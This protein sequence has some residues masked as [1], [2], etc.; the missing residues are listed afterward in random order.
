LSA[1]PLVAIG[2]MS[3]SAYLWHQPLLAFARHG[4]LTEPSKAAYATLAFLSFPLA[5]LSWRFIEQPFRA[6]GVFTRKAI[7]ISSLTGSIMFIAIGIVGHMA[8]GFD[9]RM[10]QS[11]LTAD[12]IDKK[13]NV[14]FGLNKICEETFTVSL[15]CRT[16]DAPE[17]LVWGDSYAMHLV[18]G[19][20][21]SEPDAK[22]IQ[23]T[24]SVCGPFFDAAP[25]Y[26]P[27]YPMSWA[28]GCL[29][30]TANI[31]EWLKKNRTVKYAVLSSPF[32]L[33]LS[34]GGKLL[35]RDGELSQAN[36]ELAVKEFEKTLNEIKQMGIAPIV[37]SPP[38]ANGIDLGQCLAKAAWRGLNLGDCDFEVDKI[39]QDRLDAYH[40]LERIEKTA[41]V[42]R[43]DALICNDSRCITH[44]D[45]T[46]IY[47]DV[48]HLSHEGS[49]ALGKK[50]HF[51]RRITE[52]SL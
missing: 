18:E 16:D 11:G 48:G 33:Y 14:N 39:T 45:A 23:M 46:F 26:E 8:N 1:Q 34:A 21:A 36:V 42:V 15:D 24:K 47:R 32:T 29:E 28:R 31:R 4:A 10:T 41:A 37:F 43:L 52:R 25:V 35:L 20:L 38:P 19:I 6:K 3:Y 44:L 17:I 30:F 7:F 49:A 40:F 9:G 13:L 12:L 50:Y 51:Y 27:K 22:I 2:L 5:Y